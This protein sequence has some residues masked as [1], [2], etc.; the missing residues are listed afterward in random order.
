MLFFKRRNEFVLSFF[1]DNLKKKY[2]GLKNG[3]LKKDI[4][5]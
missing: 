5:D 1:L 2:I 3:Y 4:L